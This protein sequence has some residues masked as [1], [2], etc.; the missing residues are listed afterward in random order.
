M[1]CVGICHNST[2]L[3]DKYECNNSSDMKKIGIIVGC[4]VGGIVV[5]VIIAVSISVVVKKSKQ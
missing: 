3:N 4:V 5:I 1:Y 2:T